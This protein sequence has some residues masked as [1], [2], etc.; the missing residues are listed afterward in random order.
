M[1]YSHANNSVIRA[2]Y[3]GGLHATQW[4]MGYEKARWGRHFR[5]LRF[6]DARPY[7]IAVRARF[8]SR[9]VEAHFAGSLQSRVSLTDFSLNGR[10]TGFREG[11]RG[12]GISFLIG[13]S[14]FVSLPILRRSHQISFLR[15]PLPRVWHCRR[16]LSQS[17]N[18]ISTPS[19][20]R[21]LLS[22]IPVFF[23]LPPPLSLFLS[24]SLPHLPRRL[25]T[26]NFKHCTTSETKATSSKMHSIVIFARTTPN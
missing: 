20:S 11:A 3:R 19:R 9:S 25:F 1:S 22:R 4:K 26:A 6:Q 23:S 8:H 7:R 2:R 21:K 18:S 15:D 24:L 5:S 13:V 12:T 14:Y 16:Q 10:S 17:G